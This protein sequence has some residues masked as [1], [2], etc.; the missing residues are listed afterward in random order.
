MKLKVCG[1]KH[2]TGDIA[3]LGPDYLGFILWKGSPRYTGDSLPETEADGPARVGVFV[4]APLREVLEYSRK[5]QLGLLQLHGSESPEYCQKLRVLLNK[6]REHAPK[7][8]KAFAPGKDFDFRILEAYLPL[9]DYFLFD[10]RGPMPG[11]NGR[12]FDWTVLE[13]YPYEKPYFLSGG[14]GPG[15]TTALQDFA[16]S[17]AARRCYAIDVNSKFE[18]RPG[19]KD[20]QA[21]KT[22]MSAAF[23]SAIKPSDL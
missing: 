14:I 15:S 2:N 5:G 4:D 7:I 13:K 18:T 12:T 22:F 10:S 9:C 16:R 17:P 20:P 21:L 6:A 3:R 23:W 11:G 19:E 1:M 8:I